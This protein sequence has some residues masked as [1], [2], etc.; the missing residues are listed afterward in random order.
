MIRGAKRHDV[1][2]PRGSGYPTPGSRFQ[3]IQHGNAKVGFLARLT[4]PHRFADGA[5]GSTR[6]QSAMHV[7][8]GRPQRASTFLRLGRSRLSETCCLEITS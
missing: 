3:G 8:L 4:H 5:D 2:R 7:R 1:T 6:E